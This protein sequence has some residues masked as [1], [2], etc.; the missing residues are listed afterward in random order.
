[1]KESK[2]NNKIQDTFQ[3][4]V[5][6]VPNPPA[7]QIINYIYTVREK[8]LENDFSFLIQKH[9]MIHYFLLFDLTMKINLQT[10]QEKNRASLNPKVP[11]LLE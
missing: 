9:L 1:M 3:P 5:I 4:S 10:C 6:R 11:I 8:I 7:L 2:K